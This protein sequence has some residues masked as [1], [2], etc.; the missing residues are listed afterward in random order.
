V[1]PDAQRVAI[2]MAVYGDDY[3]VKMI[4]RPGP[5]HYR[6]TDDRI[7]TPDYLTDINAMHKAEQSLPMERRYAYFDLLVGV[8][9]GDLYR[10]TCCGTIEGDELTI[11][12]ASAAHRAEAFLLA[13]NLWDDSK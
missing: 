2:A 8:S 11:A 9:H 12:H 1:S 7:P 10:S 6:W 5:Q 4:C 13:L 3:S